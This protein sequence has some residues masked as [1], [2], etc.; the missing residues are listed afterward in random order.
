MLVYKGATVIVQ[1]VPAQVCATCGERY[2]D[3]GVV[4]QL[5]SV[6]KEAAGAGVVLDVRRYALPA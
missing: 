4:A 5:L 6:V 2:F 1:G 3:A